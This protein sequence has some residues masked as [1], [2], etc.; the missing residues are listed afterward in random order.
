MTEIT[1]YKVKKF[2]V[3]QLLKNLSILTKAVA[4]LTGYLTFLER[5]SLYIYPV[6]HL[7]LASGGRQ[8]VFQNPSIVF[9]RFA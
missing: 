1:N 7:T 9:N 4:T 3:D 2:T 8:D 5:A 6:A